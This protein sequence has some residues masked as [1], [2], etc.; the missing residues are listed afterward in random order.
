MILLRNVLRTQ[1]W[2]C[3]AAGDHSGECPVTLRDSFP[4]LE[5]KA[6]QNPLM[7][8]LSTWYESSSQ[9]KIW[10]L[11]P[12]LW[13]CEHIMTRAQSRGGWIHSW[14]SG[15]TERKEEYAI[16]L[17]S[18]SSQCHQRL[19]STPDETNYSS[20]YEPSTIQGCDPVAYHIVSPGREHCTQSP[21]N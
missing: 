13:A 17:T 11:S 10:K 4:S 12:V 14:H 5:L 8:H 20:S 1:E 2:R 9:Y 15:S 18:S 16:N 7:G 3:C 19:M 6:W 21:A